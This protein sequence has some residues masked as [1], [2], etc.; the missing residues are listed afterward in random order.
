MGIVIFMKRNSLSTQSSILKLDF[1]G[2]C[3]DSSVP[4]L[5]QTKEIVCPCIISLE[6]MCFSPSIRSASFGRW[7]LAKPTIISCII[8]GKK[9]SK[10]F[11]RFVYVAR[12][13]AVCRPRH[14]SRSTRMYGRPLP[15]TRDPRIV[16]SFRN[17]TNV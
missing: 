17:Q 16:Q 15:P 6:E 13:G 4:C 1:F 8:R 9:T 14:R 11:I 2:P 7:L 10:F 12:G 5:I 3:G